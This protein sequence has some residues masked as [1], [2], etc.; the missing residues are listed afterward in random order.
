MVKVLVRG[1]AASGGGLRCEVGVQHRAVH[2]RAALDPNR[3][4]GADPE[5]SLREFF[6]RLRRARGRK[7]AR[8]APTPAQLQLR[9]RPCGCFNTCARSGSG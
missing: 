5:P 4:H 2:S 9:Y 3:A 6:A 8:R 7:G 1:G